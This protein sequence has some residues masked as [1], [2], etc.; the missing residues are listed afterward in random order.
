MRILYYGPHRK[1][2]TLEK[3][4]GAE[5][6]AEL[7]DLL[8]SSDF[9]SLH[10]PLTPSTERLIGRAEF[11]LMK[12][13]AVFINTARGGLVDQPA[14]YEALRSGQIFAAGLDVTAVEPIPPDDP[15][16]TLNNVIITPHI[17]SASVRTR[18]KMAMMAAE[19]LL[20]GIMGRS[21]E[22]C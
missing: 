19:N 18:E 10:V 13:T 5:Y 8:S 2:E 9:I 22:L 11:Q 20:A 1:S 16:L 14:L 7:K 6:V 15:L 4:L 21:P 12:K 3:E 17:G